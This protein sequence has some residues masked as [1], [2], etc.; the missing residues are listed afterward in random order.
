VQKVPHIHDRYVAFAAPEGSTISGGTHAT[1]DLAMGAADRL[2]KDRSGHE[3]SS[4][5]EEW[6][7]V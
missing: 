1:A 3:C 5:C 7:E 4:K 2:V 6:H